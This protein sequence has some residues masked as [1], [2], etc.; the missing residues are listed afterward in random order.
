ML[1]PKDRVDYL[2]YFYEHQP[3]EALIFDEATNTI[4]KDKKD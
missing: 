3:I 2:I 1:Q 4:V